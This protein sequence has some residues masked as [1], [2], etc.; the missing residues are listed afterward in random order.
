MLEYRYFK[1]DKWNKSF[2][3]AITYGALVEVVRFGARRKVLIKWDGQLYI[4]M[5]WCLS[6]IPLKEASTQVYQKRR[7]EC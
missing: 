2:G 5:L 1:G 4:T 7:L 6:K 3:Y